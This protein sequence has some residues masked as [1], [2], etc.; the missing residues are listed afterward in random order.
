MRKKRKATSDA[1]QILYRR[2]YEG[3][4]AR[5]AQLEEARAEELRARCNK[6]TEAQR[7][8]LR[9]EAMRLYHETAP[10]PMDADRP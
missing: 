9:E 7:R 6:L 2:Y 10:K 5:I 1:V 8:Q 4:P 3:K